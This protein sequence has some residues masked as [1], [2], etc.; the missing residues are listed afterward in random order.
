MVK[1]TIIILDYM[2]ASRVVENV[3]SLLRQK[4]DFDYKIFVIDNSCNE[5]N[6]KI[7]QDGLVKYPNIKLQINSVNL[8]YTKAHNQF[9]DSLEGDYVFVINPDILWKNDDIIAK[10]VDYLDSHQDVGILGPKQINENGEVAMTIRAFPKLYLQ[11]ARRTFFRNFPILNKK[12]AYDEMQHLD[13]TKIQ[14]VDWLQSSFVAVRKKLWDKVGGLCEDYFLFMSDPEICLEAWKNNYRVVYFPEVVV[15][16]DGKRVSAGGF[17][18][19]FQSWVMRAHL[20]D[21]IKY[22]IKHLFD[23]NPREEYYKRNG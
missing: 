23:K 7:L 10:M 14:D 3:E 22:R 15:Y 6:T 18:K 12:V 20:K 19:F 1:A 5:A 9:N 17:K 16:A 13:Y 4:V 2:K 8:G 11:V 21:S